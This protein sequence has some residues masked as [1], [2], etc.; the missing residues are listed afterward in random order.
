MGDLYDRLMNKVKLSIQAETGQR[1]FVWMQ[2]ERD[3]RMGWEALRK[4][5]LGLHSSGKGL[6]W[7][8]KR[9]S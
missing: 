1:K 9:I 7:D 3:A 8:A 6:P 4:A 2:G 5:L